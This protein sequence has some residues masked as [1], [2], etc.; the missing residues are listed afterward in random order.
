MLDLRQL[1]IQ[2]LRLRQFLTLLFLKARLD[3]PA[4]LAQLGH[5]DLR[6]P[7]GQLALLQPFQDQ[8]DLLAPLVPLDRLDRQEPADLPDQ[9]GRQARVVHQDQ[10]VL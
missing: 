2:V 1:Q 4:Q 7:L 8:L 5:L 10:M 6:G 9:A 3:R